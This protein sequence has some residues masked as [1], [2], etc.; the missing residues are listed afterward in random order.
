MFSYFEYKNSVGATILSAI[1]GI[2]V[3][4]GIAEAFEEPGYLLLSLVGALLMILASRIA[5]RKARKES[6]KLAA[7]KQEAGQ[8]AMNTTRNNTFDYAPHMRAERQI[9][10]LFSQ[11]NVL[12]SNGEY[13]SEIE[14][15]LQASYLE[16]NN[17]LCWNSLGRAYRCNGEYANALICYNKA[18]EINPNDGSFYC[19]IGALYLYQDDPATAV[20]YYKK[21]IT[22]E[23][24][25]ESDYAGA[26]AGYALAVCRNGDVQ[27]GMYLLSEAE[28][29]G[30]KNGDVIRQ[31][32]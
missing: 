22:L 20:Q 10:D 31:S 17:S 21:G 14:V 18:K 27:Y 9:N 5:A 13:E 32:F 28:K 26:L 7:A 15:L 2:L 11:A 3:A 29:H 30:Y 25:S 23:Y 6:E 4:M 19:N 8:D 24:D 16:P 1:G 12:H